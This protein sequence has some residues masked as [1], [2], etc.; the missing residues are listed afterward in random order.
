MLETEIKKQ[1]EAIQANT[2]ALLAL[3][4]QLKEGFPMRRKAPTPAELSQQKLE[5][6]LKETKEKMAE[7]LAEVNDNEEKAAE[8]EEKPSEPK[9]VEKTGPQPVK[10]D[11]PTI[12]EVREA[13][14]KL[15]KKHGRMAAKQ[16]IK[17]VGYEVLPDVP[18]EKYAEL[19]RN[20]LK[21]MEG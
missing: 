12:E 9:P 1:T 10:T 2:K 16:L 14:V 17:D 11:P 5:D 15:S 4:E 20:T 19:M 21:A 8:P 18:E 3:Q 6:E 7:A 13:M